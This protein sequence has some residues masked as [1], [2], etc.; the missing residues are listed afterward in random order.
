MPLDAVLESL[1]D[2]EVWCVLYFYLFRVLCYI[3]VIYLHALFTRDVHR[4]T[5]F[6][7]IFEKLQQ[8]ICDCLLINYFPNAIGR[9]IPSCI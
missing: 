7:I 8:N 1:K 6:C 5:F 3:Y 2:I 4:K 9:V